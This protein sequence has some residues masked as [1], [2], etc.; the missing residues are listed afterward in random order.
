MSRWCSNQLSYSPEEGPI[1]VENYCDCKHHKPGLRHKYR[2][3]KPGKANTRYMHTTLA[4]NCQCCGCSGALRFP[5]AT[6]THR[7]AADTKPLQQTHCE[8][9]RTAGSTHQCRPRTNGRF[10]RISAAA[11][12]IAFL[13]RITPDADYGESLQRRHSSTTAAGCPA[14]EMAMPLSDSR[15]RDSEAPAW[16]Y[17]PPAHQST[18]V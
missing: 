11:S 12:S 15:A 7:S 8:I 18:S 16:Q 4:K 1:I 17:S 13:C 3:T 9:R 10:A 2:Y 5:A 6:Q 14:P